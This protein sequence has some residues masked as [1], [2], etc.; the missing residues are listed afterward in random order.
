M[1][2]RTERKRRLGALGSVWCGALLC[3]GLLAPSAALASS[4]RH[5][6]IY[7]VNR[8]AATP[9][10][11]IYGGSRS[12]KA[13]PAVLERLTGI[14]GFNIASSSTQPSDV[15]AFATYLHDR[16]PEQRQ[17]PLWFLSIEVFRRDDLF[18][19]ELLTMP[20]LMDKIPPEL[21]EGVKLSPPISFTPPADLVFPDGLV[22]RPDGSLKVSHYDL[23]LR[24]GG[25]REQMLIPRI[26]QFVTNYDK[27][28]TLSPTQMRMFEAT[29]ARM[30]SYKWVPVILL[31][32]YST[33]LMAVMK[34][35]G[36][37]ARHKEAME[38]LA[39][40][41]L[42]YKFVVIDFSSLS[43]FGGWSDGLFDGIHGSTELMRFMLKKVVAKSGSA[44]DP[45][46]PYSIPPAARY[47]SAP[48]SSLPFS[49]PPGE[50]SQLP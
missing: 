6:K 48:F 3:V 18:D 12:Q 43:S 26:K 17:F 34:Q 27:F 21:K 46:V 36:Y 8:P 42:H 11:V 28:K 39:D 50:E 47:Y 24:N 14:P 4:P 35:H 49:T 16:N 40:L 22:W 25:T 7:L 20:E 41:Q 9:Q 2:S 32:P 31:P 44:F 38:Y 37:E 15:L 1:N 23:V 29:L 45:A 5:L 10:L 13:E 19:R 33:E 30:N